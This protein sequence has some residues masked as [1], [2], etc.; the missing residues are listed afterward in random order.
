MTTIWFVLGWIV[1][2]L[3]VF[4]TASSQ[5][6]GFRGMGVAVFG[7]IAVNV[8]ALIVAVGLSI[9]IAG[10]AGRAALAVFLVVSL[11]LPAIALVSA[12]WF[13]AG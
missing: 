9:W 4:V 1:A 11:P 3:L 7:T 5:R 6:D 10:T 8:L 2:N 12:V 13:V